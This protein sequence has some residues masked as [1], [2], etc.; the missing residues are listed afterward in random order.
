MGQ[1]ISD[2]CHFRSSPTDG[3]SFQAMDDVEFQHELED[4]L[5]PLHTFAWRLCGRADYADDLVQETATRAWRARLRFKPGTNMRAWTFTI[6]RNQ[7]L[8]DI[9]KEKRMTDMPDESLERIQTVKAVQEE[10][11]HVEDAE[12]ALSRIAP[13]R[14]EALLLVAAD[15]YT[16]EEAAD[17]CGC[18]LGTLKSRVSRARTDLAQQLAD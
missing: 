12:A 13:E 2:N 15:G 3:E 9:R 17:M 6:L 18:K 16:Y 11:L 14:R 10:R 5:S 4:L 8:S 7:F 1:K